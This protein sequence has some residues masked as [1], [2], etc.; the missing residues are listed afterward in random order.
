MEEKF[1]C[2]VS[3]SFVVQFGV[4]W[5]TNKFQL[6]VEFNQKG[7]VT[8]LWTVVLVFS[9]LLTFKLGY[10]YYFVSVQFYHPLLGV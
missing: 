8:F 7:E 4:T 9:S 10:Y 6:L 2:C 3:F 1:S 5:G